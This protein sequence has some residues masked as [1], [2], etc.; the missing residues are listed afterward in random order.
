MSNNFDFT[1]SR[2]LLPGYRQAPD[3]ETAIQQKYHNHRNEIRS[4]VLPNP[5]LYSSHP[6]IHSAAHLHQ[7][8]SN[9]N[10]SMYK[11]YPDVAQVDRLYRSENVPVPHV[12]QVIHTYR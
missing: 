3:Y 7:H 12:D 11:H 8:N 2:A 5:V 1:S 10:P 6:D 4:N 9:L